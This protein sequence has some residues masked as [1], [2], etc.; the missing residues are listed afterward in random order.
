MH[1]TSIYGLSSIILEF[2]LDTDIDALATAVQAA[3]INEA[4][5]ALPSSMPGPPIYVKANPNGFPIVVIALTLDVVAAPEL[6]QYA[7]TVLA[8]KL[9]Q[10]DG[11]ANAINGAATPG[12][13]IQVN[14]RAL[15]D[16]HV[17]TAAVKS[18]LMPLPRACPRERSMTGR[19]L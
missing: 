9:S 19:S 17:S 10:I 3:I 15:A 8:G 11:V 1:A 4:S 16:M 2:S 12:V 7:D 18:A 13:R 5:T 14:P 6:Y